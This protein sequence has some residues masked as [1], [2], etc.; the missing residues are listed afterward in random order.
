MAI[1]AAGTTSTLWTV[2]PLIVMPRIWAARSA[3][4]EGFRAS[5]TPPAL[6]RPPAWTCALMTTVPPIRR[7]TASA[8]VGVEATS[9]SN[10]GMPAAL[11]NARA[12]YS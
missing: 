2:R 6:P 1:S 11:S 12:W 7:A 9:P 5:L 3:A 10:I 4:S 8:S